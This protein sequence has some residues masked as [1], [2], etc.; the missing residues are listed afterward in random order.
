[1]SVSR[2]LSCSL[3]IAALAGCED[4]PNVSGVDGFLI[5]SVD[6]TPGFATIFVPDTIRVSDRVQFQAQATAKDGSPLDLSRFV[7]RTSDPTVAVVDSFGLVRPIRYGTVEITASATRIGRANL[8]ILPATDTVL[9]SP[10]VDTVLVNDPTVPPRVTAQ[11]HARSFDRDGVELAG[12]RYEWTASSG[13]GVIDSTGLVRGITPGVVTLTAVSA[14]RAGSATVVVLEAIASIAVAPT[15]DT[16]FVDEP[17]DATQSKRQLVASA[18]D[19]YGGDLAG[20]MYNWGSSAP[21]VA[22]VS[23][24]GL[25]TATGLGEAVVTV[26]AGPRLTSATVRVVP[27]VN[28]IS[29][30]S[31]LDSVLALDTL[32]L[33]ATAFDYSGQ[34]V[35]RQYTWTSSAPA[36]ATVDS[37]GRVVFQAAGEVTFTARTAWRSASVTVIALERRLEFADA[38]D[39]YTCGLAPLGRG[40]CWGLDSAGRTAIAPDSSCT[41]S[42]VPPGGPCTL[43]PKRMNRPDLR[44]RMI[45]T[46]ASFACGI[47]ES[48]N[49]YCWGDDGLGQI[50]NGG[51]GAGSNPSL[52]TVKQ[53]RFSTVAAGHNHACAL[54]LNGVAYCWG[55]DAFGQLGDNRRIHSTTPIPTADTTLQFMAI[56]AGAR[57]TCA[58]TVTGVAYCWGDGALGQLG[59]GGTAVA[60]VPTI[61]SGGLTFAS[62][63]AGWGHT[64]GITTLGM[65]YCWGDN[66]RAQLGVGVAGGTALVPTLVASAM[67][68]SA[69]SAGAIHTCGIAGGIAMCW[70]GSDFGEVGDGI[71][72]V[73]TV[74]TPTVVS[75]SFAASSISVGTS[76]TCAISSTT[77]LLWCWGSN[78][79]GTLGN[80]Y[81]AAVRAT[82]QLVARPR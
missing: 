5:A 49:V 47:D 34:V 15:L 11:F 17:I 1:M 70:G 59:N 43:L 64:C 51:K 62:I 2:L 67:T 66:S 29:V 50:G 73:H 78:R 82:P 20:V 23:G 12:V 37:S 6:V 36:V 44:F 9:V 39:Q 18:K 4:G 76:H 10:A 72:P 77:G 26:T 41:G 71:E 61:V 7:W 55:D 22:S 57:H 25:V 42:L 13:A 58:L 32:Q 19:P 80:E 21:S 65:L 79:W 52:A 35:P 45:S 60:E 16:I 14:E 56:T 28:S 63:S 38:A 8:V 27:I 3:L 30:T 54:N 40:Y 69:V 31:P 53:E 46:G 81:Q 75:G 48:R 68:F 24:S 33:V 74:V